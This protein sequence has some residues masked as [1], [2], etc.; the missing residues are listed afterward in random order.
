MLYPL[1][2]L[3]SCIYKTPALS[4]TVHWVNDVKFWEM[5][6]FSH[7]LN[8]E[9]EH[10][11]WFFKFWSNLRKKKS[12]YLHILILSKKDWDDVELP[13]EWYMGSRH[14]QTYL[15]LNTPKSFPQYLHWS[16]KMSL[17]LEG[18]RPH[19]HQVNP[20]S[21]CVCMNGSF[22]FKPWPTWSGS[23]N[24][25]SLIHPANTYWVEVK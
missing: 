17:F 8:Q 13:E 11:S 16:I 23:G 19:Q 22:S 2:V 25:S 14:P 9:L 20:R 18:K 4:V 6:G 12:L 24:C 10:L 5:T 7:S 15:S 21:H 1:W 3:K